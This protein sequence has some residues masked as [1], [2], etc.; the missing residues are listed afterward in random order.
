MTGHSTVGTVVLG[1][2]LAVLAV[3]PAGPFDP[4]RVRPVT[5]QGRSGLAYYSSVSRTYRFTAEPSRADIPQL[6][7]AR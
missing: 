7:A 2:L 4:F 6:D 5:M 1:I 3:G